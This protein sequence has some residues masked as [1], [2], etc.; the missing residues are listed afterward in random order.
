MY[1]HSYSYTFNVTWSFYSLRYT[2]VLTCHY[3]VL[4][5]VFKG[6]SLTLATLSLEIFPAESRGFVVSLGSIAW[7]LSISSLSLVAFLL[8]HVTWRYTMLAS[9]LIGMHSL[10]T[11]WYVL[12]TEKSLVRRIFCRAIQVFPLLHICL[13]QCL[14]WAHILEILYLLE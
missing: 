11:R 13:W 14:I 2:R 6:A 7:A 1:I 5:I 3:I 8:R 12:C 4:F 10:A 9:G